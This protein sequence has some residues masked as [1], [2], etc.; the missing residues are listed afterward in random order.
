MYKRNV[1]K[2]MSFII[3]ITIALTLFAPIRADAYQL[4]AYIG[5]VKLVSFGNSPFASPIGFMLCQGQELKIYD[6]QALY[7]L[8]GTT[9]GGDGKTTFKLPDLRGAE[10]LPGCRYIISVDGLFPSAY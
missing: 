7:A 1:R 5:E 3:A 2:Y 4:D 10:P 6:Y 9:Y 8:I